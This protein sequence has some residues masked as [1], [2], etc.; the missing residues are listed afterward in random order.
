MQDIYF[1]LFVH[2]HTKFGQYYLVVTFLSTTPK[3]FS[4]AITKMQHIIYLMKVTSH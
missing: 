2:V 1:L 3:I 4:L